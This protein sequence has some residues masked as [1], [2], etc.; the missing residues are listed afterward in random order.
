MEKGTS[1]CL[2]VMEGAE[3]TVTRDEKGS[4]TELDSA[5]WG[6]NSILRHRI[7]YHCFA[8]EVKRSTCASFSTFCFSRFSQELQSRRQSILLLQ[9]TKTVESS[10]LFLMRTDWRISINSLP[11]PFDIHEES[12]EDE[13]FSFPRCAR[14]VSPS[15]RLL[16]HVHH[17]L[18]LY[19][20][21]RLMMMQPWSRFRVC[22]KGSFDGRLRLLLLSRHS[23]D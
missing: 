3:R 13:M 15:N 8:Q 12:A 6:K 10:P 21:I 19:R 1:L 9:E 16:T 20:M 22:G 4:D 17:H 7:L 18:L 23:Y 14:L 5:L 2:C 11:I